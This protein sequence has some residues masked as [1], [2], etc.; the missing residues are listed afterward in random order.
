MASLVLLVAVVEIWFF[1][2]NHGVRRLRF[3][4]AQVLFSLLTCCLVFIMSF[5]PW[6]RAVSGFGSMDQNWRPCKYA[7]QVNRRTLLS[8][9][10]TLC[11]TVAWL[12]LV[13]VTILVKG[14]VKRHS[15]IRCRSDI[16]GLMPAM[17]EISYYYT[18]RL[19]LGI[20]KIAK[21]NLPTD[22]RNVTLS[23]VLDF[24][25]LSKSRF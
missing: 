20:L 21:D 2:C 15:I 6:A 7:Q 13:T 5:W 8:A 17:Y 12:V 14:E 24:F 10:R 1:V 16:R 23:Q 11:G 19:L 4:V 22:C 18:L 25:I 9:S 3:Y